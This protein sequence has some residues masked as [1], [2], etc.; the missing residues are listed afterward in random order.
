MTVTRQDL[1]TFALGLGAAVLV[2]VG[3][4]LVESE[5]L[6]ADPE[7]WLRAAAAGVL[8]AAGRYLVTELTERRAPRAGRDGDAD[9]S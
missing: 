2:A 4:A 9:V 1:V 7:A 3:E 5:G 6:F 8:A